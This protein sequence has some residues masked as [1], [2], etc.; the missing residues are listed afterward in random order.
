MKTLTNSDLLCHVTV[1]RKSLWALAIFCLLI[2][3]QKEPKS[4]PEGTNGQ[5]SG[6][7]VKAKPDITVHQG[8]SIQAAVN[9][10]GPGSVIKVMPGVYNEAIT[11]TTEGISIRGSGNVIINNPGD[12]EDGINVRPGAN[13]FTLENVTIQNFKENG[14]FLVRVDNFLLRNVTT[15]NNGEY[16]LFPVVCTNGRIEHCTASGHSDTGIYV[17]QSTDIDISHCTAFANVLG[18]EVENCSRVTVTQ[19]HTYDNVTGILAVLL[20]QL[21]RKESS[22][23]WITKNIVSNNNHV[24]FAPQDG[25]FESIVPSGIGIL[26]VGTDN[27]TVEQNQVKGNKFLGIGIFSALTLGQL[28]NIPPEAFDIEPHADHAKVVNNNLVNNA[29][30]PS[31]IPFLPAVDLIWDGFGT[32]NCWSGNNFTSSVPSPLPSCN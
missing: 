9:S 14:V 19:N 4:V 8:G 12:L 13:N 31:P 24:N 5:N 2:S 32:G 10:A 28:A 21:T 23:I 7:S 29:A 3:C 11:I 15:I 25:G 30:G 6:F 27:T 1:I 18:I 22:D 17:G 20:P 26:V 16:G